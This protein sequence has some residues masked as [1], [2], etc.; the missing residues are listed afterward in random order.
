MMKY[1]GV[2]LHFKFY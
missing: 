2:C 1:A